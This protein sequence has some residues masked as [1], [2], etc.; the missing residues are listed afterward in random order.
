[1]I[2]PS[3]ILKAGQPVYVTDPSLAPWGTVGRSTR[4]VATIVRPMRDYGRQTASYYIARLW[5]GQ[6]KVYSADF[7]D[8]RTE[9]QDATEWE[10]NN[11]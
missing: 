6:E 5:N 9:G 3:Q 1:M 8:L 11:V 4:H 10:R 7:V 2:Y